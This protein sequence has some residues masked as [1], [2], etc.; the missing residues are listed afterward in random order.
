MRDHWVSTTHRRTVLGL[1]SGVLALCVALIVAWSH[2]VQTHG[3]LTTTVLFDREIVRILNDRCV[4]CH[5]DGGLAFSLVTYEQ[6]WLQGRAMRSSTLRRHMPPWSAVAG[7]G[8]FVNDNHL[9]LRE[10]QFLVSW[11]EGLGPRNAGKVFLNVVDPKAAAPR[12]I[13]A[14]THSDHWQL[15]EP[16]LTRRLTPTTIEARTPDVV[17]RSVLDLDLTSPR[18]VRALEFMPGD[19]RVV[20]AASFSLEGTGQWLGSWTPW[21]SFVSLPDGVVYRLPAK[22]RIVVDIHY[23]GTSEPVVDASTLGVFFLEP[24]SS[25]SPE[26]RVPSPESR[27]PNPGLK[28]ATDLVLDARPISG[29]QMLKGT[30]RLTSDTRV[31]AI[32]PEI[33]PGLSSLEVS[34]RRPDGGTDVLL[35]LTEP[36]VEWP[37]PYLLKTP[38]LLARGTEVFVVARPSMGQPRQLRV[39][40]SRY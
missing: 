25:S 1:G 37:T 21:H 8:E 35:A 13:R 33:M 2:P 30:S 19:R 29:S 5:V 38:R 36:S 22:A 15:G 39:R 17:R 28:L 10:S 32:Q 20:R 6:T 24:R 9:T 27:A 26:S 7:Y 34:A 12:E 14:T 31:W 16:D 3:S 23:R 40:I 4:M 18:R 11:V